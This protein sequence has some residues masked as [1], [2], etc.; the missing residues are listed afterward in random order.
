[1]NEFL[2][3]VSR[4]GTGPIKSYADFV[5][6]AANS[7]SVKAGTE[8]G[9]TSPQAVDT[10]LYRR[11]AFGTAGGTM[12]GTPWGNR[13]TYDSAWSN[14]MRHCVDNVDIY[15]DIMT[16]KRIALF[17]V[18]YLGMQEA[19]YVSLARNGYTSSSY[20]RFNGCAC[21]ECV[22]FDFQKGT[23]VSSRPF[24]AVAGQPFTPP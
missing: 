7:A 6:W 24:S 5:S 11:V 2:L 1:M 3:P 20:G 9:N 17:K 18:N 8:A 15:T 21:V 12:W 23:V 14:I 19:G 10:T 4:G 16:N 22:Y 13:F